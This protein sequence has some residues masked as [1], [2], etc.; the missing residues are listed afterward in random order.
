MFIIFRVDDWLPE[1]L[2]RFPPNHIVYALDEAPA[3]P[4]GEQPRNGV[5]Q[6]VLESRYHDSACGAW[7]TLHIAKDKRSSD[8]VRF[9]SASPRDDNRSVRADKLREALGLVKVNFL[10][11]HYIKIIM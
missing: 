6:S 10:L 8:A 1:G 11:G 7:H 5:S 9:A 3:F 2:R 4:C